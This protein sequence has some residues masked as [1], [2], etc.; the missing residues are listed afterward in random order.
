MFPEPITDERRDQIVEAMADRIKQFGMVTPAI[1]FLEANK[2]VT[3][4]GGQ[5]MHFFA[6][7]V[8]VFFNTF[9]DYAFFF[10]DR[11]NVEML[12]QRLESIALEE[13]KERKEAKAAK[14]KAKLEAKKAKQA[15]KEA[16]KATGGKDM[17]HGDEGETD[18][19]E[20][21][22]RSLVDEAIKIDPD[23]S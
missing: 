2:P 12:I 9:E 6:P 19:K 20:V 17:P 8:G 10:D 18:N 3:Y 11:N 16:E 22:D 4:I 15:K 7:I 1:F 21:T 14:K 5:T 13:E 23:K